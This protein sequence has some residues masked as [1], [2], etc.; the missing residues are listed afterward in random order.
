MAVETRVC[1]DGLPDIEV[2]HRDAETVYVR[3]RGVED[4]F[5]TVWGDPTAIANVA[6]AILE[7]IGAAA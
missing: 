6:R 7:G 1:I 2:K 4:V 3:L 5:V